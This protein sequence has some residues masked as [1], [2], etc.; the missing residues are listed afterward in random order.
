MITDLLIVSALLIVIFGGL[1]YVKLMYWEW[2]EE[3]D[4]SRE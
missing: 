4:A 3:R 2:L 1:G